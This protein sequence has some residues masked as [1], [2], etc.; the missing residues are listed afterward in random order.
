M[1]CGG[2]PVSARAHSLALALVLVWPAHEAV[3]Q[4]HTLELRGVLQKLE[5]MEVAQGK[6]LHHLESIERQLDEVRRTFPTGQP[7]TPPRT[8]A[9]DAPVSIEGAPRK[10]PDSATLVLIEYADFQCPFCRDFARHTLPELEKRYVATGKVQ[11]VFRNLPLQEIH[12]QALMAA[13]AA[14]C[15]EE[16][17][18][19]WE[20]HDALFMDQRLDETSLLA[21]VRA[22]DLDLARFSTCVQGPGAVKVRQDLAASRALGLAVTPTFLIGRRQATGLVKVERVITGVKDTAAFAAVLDSMLAESLAQR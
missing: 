8:V 10:G 5:N 20:V 13:E 16:Q 7:K 22:A 9:P 18:K 12:P 21:K 11:L 17:G 3:G 6:V 4:E 1:V 19:F 15:A 2:A 14:E